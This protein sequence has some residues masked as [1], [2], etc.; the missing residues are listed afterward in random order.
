MHTKRSC[1][2]PSKIKRCWSET[3]TGESNNKILHTW[4][5]YRPFGYESPFISP[6]SL[7]TSLFPIACRSRYLSRPTGC[8]SAGSRERILLGWK[9]VQLVPTQVKQQAHSVTCTRSHPVRLHGL[10]QLI[11]VPILCSKR[12][13]TLPVHWLD[14]RNLKYTWLDSSQTFLATWNQ[15][16]WPKATHP[17]A[18]AMIQS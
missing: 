4:M 2:A 8:N 14:G 3:R 15:T 1:S 13:N 5:K 10:I 11:Q 7:A 6:F 18:V 12:G 9:Q 16:L 17:I